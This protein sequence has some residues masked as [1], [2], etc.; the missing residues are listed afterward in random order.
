[1]KDNQK[2]TPTK[3]AINQRKAAIRARWGER[4]G[5]S[6]QVRVD[7]DAASA[8]LTVPERDRRTV[9]SDGIRSSVKTYHTLHKHGK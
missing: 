4:A 7:A 5:K 3:A 6:K 9:A 1:M 8:L 2:Y